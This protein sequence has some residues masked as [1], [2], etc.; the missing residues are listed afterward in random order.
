MSLHLNPKLPKLLA[1]ETLAQDAPKGDS[2][3][4]SL[5]RWYDRWFFK[6]A[7]L[8]GSL[9]SFGRLAMTVRWEP[10]SRVL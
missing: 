5:G 4:L 9:R 1:S 6:Q 2:L 10:G 7:K 3:L 8:S